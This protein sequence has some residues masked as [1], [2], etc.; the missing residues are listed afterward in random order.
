MSCYDS[1]SAQCTTSSRFNGQQRTNLQIYHT[2]TFTLTSGYQYIAVTDFVEVAP[3]DILGYKSQGGVLRAVDS[4]SEP[5]FTDVKT[6]DVTNTASQSALSS[7]KRQMIRAISTHRTQ[8]TYPIHYTAAGIKSLEFLVKSK[9]L[10]TYENVTKNITVDEGIN[11]AILD[12]PVYHKTNS[13]LTLKVLSH[14]GKKHPYFVYTLLAFCCRLGIKLNNIFKI[15]I[16]Q[17]SINTG[18]QSC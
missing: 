8:F 1:V 13:P 16:I 9:R 4:T 15:I 2:F 17:L 7:P 6:T 11:Y 5:T 10:N 12:I 18:K 3:G 14:T